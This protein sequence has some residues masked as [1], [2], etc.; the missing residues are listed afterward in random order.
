MHTRLFL[1]MITCKRSTT[2]KI[3]KAIDISKSLLI[4]HEASLS[5][6]SKKWFYLRYCKSS[7]HNGITHLDDAH[8]L[9]HVMHTHNISTLRHTERNR[10]RRRLQPLGCR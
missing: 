2:L 4:I 5:F 8:H 6:A 9:A 10:G 1:A 7:S 3:T